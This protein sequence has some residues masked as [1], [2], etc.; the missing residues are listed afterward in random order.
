MRIAILT[1][2]WFPQVNGVVRTLNTTIGIL[3]QQGHEV[4][5][6]H[7]EMFRSVPMPTYPDIPLVLFPWRG[8]KRRLDAFQPEAVHLATE[9]SIGWAGRRYCL[10][11]SLPY[12][13]AYHTRFPEYVRL[14]APIPLTWSYGVMKRFHGPA[15]RTMVA[16]RS[17]YDSLTEH[18]FSHLVYWSR[19]VDLQRF[20]PRDQDMY[21]DLPRPVMVHLGRVAV[22]K[23]I[24][25]FLALDLPGSKVVIGDGPAR[26]ELQQRF[27]DAHFLG[28]RDNGD[29]ARHLSSADLLVFP[30]LTDTF[31]LV[32]LEA[33][34]S[35][36]PVAAYP[37]E[38]PV[39]LV[40]NG[41][42]GW[43][44]QDLG[45]AVRQALGVDRA[46]C[47]RFA[48]GYSW[49]ACTRQFLENLQPLGAPADGQ[50]EDPGA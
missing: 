9:G 3:E 6:I 40:R 38:G 7:P 27:P 46:A 19:G 21:P 50:V 5:C 14:R 42:N 1:D 32:M 44:D 2:A 39:D 11:R 43:V 41:E 4:L 28:Y 33:M 48:E 37:V 10:K 20:R 26:K 29:L 25:A 24:Q 35:G 49:E 17:M 12:T 36:V 15:I 16:T 22:E 18:G 23:N 31:G 30:S 34:A 45:V 47:R 8:V 13:T